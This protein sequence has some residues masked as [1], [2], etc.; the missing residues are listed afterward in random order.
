VRRYARQSVVMFGH[1]ERV[2]RYDPHSGWKPRRV[3]R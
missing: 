3:Y 2:K 1:N